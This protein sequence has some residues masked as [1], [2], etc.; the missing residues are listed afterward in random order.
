MFFVADTAP[1]RHAGLP[2][3]AG[4][5]H[6]GGVEAQV[7]D[8][9]AHERPELRKSVGHGL[10]EP[11][12][13]HVQLLGLAFCPLDSRATLLTA[14]NAIHHHLRLFILFMHVG[15]PGKKS[16]NEAIYCLALDTPYEDGDTSSLVLGCGGAASFTKSFVYLG[17]LLHCGLSRRPPRRLE[18][19]ATASSALLSYPNG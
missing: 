12:R 15:S 13:I 18:R 6:A 9:Y 10:D 2:G 3:V 7:Q 1:L 8:V 17:S 11:R 19:L 4:E 5:S 14:S 16:K